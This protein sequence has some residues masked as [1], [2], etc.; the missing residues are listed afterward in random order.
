MDKK[1]PGRPQIFKGVK[2]SS[3][4]LTLPTEAVDELSRESI[5]TE[6]SVAMI[7]RDD[8]R[9]SSG[10]LWNVIRSAACLRRARDRSRTEAKENEQ[11]LLS[12][13]AFEYTSEMSALGWDIEY[14]GQYC[15]SGYSG[16][17]E[18]VT[19]S[20]CVYLMPLVTDDMLDRLGMSVRETAG[21]EP[22]Q[23]FVEVIGLPTLASYNIASAD[24]GEGTPRVH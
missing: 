18:I 5:K 14:F 4:S 23:S 6:R 13:I 1:K 11:S 21:S 9:R 3:V 24:N 15:G 2:M 19:G 17:I 10:R 7:L 22:Q 8:L 20:G 12:V 16:R